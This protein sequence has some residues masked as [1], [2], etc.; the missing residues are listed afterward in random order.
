MR[1]IF[2][3]VWILASEDDCKSDAGH[4]HNCM[5]PVVRIQDDR[6]TLNVWIL[7]SEDDGECIRKTHSLNAWIPSRCSRMTT[8]K[9]N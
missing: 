2:I 9:D 3:I 8:H 4:F 7:A 5:D 1:S 6:M